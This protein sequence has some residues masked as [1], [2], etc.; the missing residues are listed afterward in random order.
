M[1][2]ELTQSQ[3]EIQQMVRE[4]V[5]KEV[6][7]TV[8]EREKSGRFDETEKLLRKLGKLGLWGLPFPKEDGGMGGDTVSFAL[9]CMEINKVD[10]SLGIAYAVTVSIGSWAINQYGTPAQKEKY[11]KG[12]ATGERLG[13]FGLTEPN[14]GSD[15]GACETT[16]VK[17]GDKYILNGKKIFCTNAGFADN[18]VVIAMTDKSKGVKGLT[19][20]IVEKDTP[21]FTF[22]KTEDKLGIRASV[23]RELIFENCEVPAENLLGK[24]G[25]GFKIAMTTLDVGR[26]GI[27]A[28]GV[29]IAEGAY[30]YARNYVKERIQ[31]GKPL[32]AQQY[33]SFKLAELYTEIEKCKMLV[34]SAANDKDNGKPYTLSAAMGKMASTDAAMNTATWAVQLLGGH[35]FLKDHPV[36]RYFRDAK[37]T[38]IYE[39][40]NE[41]QKIVI[42][43]QIL[44]DK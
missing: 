14:A 44:K 5:K 11:F 20:F 19:A 28:Q 32:V 31:F 37:I 42:A 10:A 1:A 7:P 15:S 30:E 41:I 26:I 8:V 43:G 2:F 29:G 13:A 39:G 24:E 9:A 33:I 16:A 40:T 3:L 34:L 17:H 12:A 27:G 21:G 36:E 35:G 22:G 38:Q 23:Q 18:Y 25:E 6:E 4:F